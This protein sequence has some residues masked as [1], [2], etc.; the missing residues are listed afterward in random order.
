MAGPG[1]AAGGVAGMWGREAVRARQVLGGSL[2]LWA[3]MLS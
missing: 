3:Q 2:S 1:R